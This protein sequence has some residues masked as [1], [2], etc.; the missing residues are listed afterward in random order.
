MNFHSLRRLTNSAANERGLGI[1]LIIQECNK[2]SA[3]YLGTI[4]CNS[5]DASEHQHHSLIQTRADLDLSGL[6]HSTESPTLK[7]LFDSCSSPLRIRSPGSRLIE[8]DS[9]DFGPRS[10]LIET[11]RCSTLKWT[12]TNWIPAHVNCEPL[13]EGKLCSKMLQ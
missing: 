12:L 7:M 4:G 10:W 11:L 13:I 3:N 1:G 6:P 2:Q 9:P 5:M 8:Q